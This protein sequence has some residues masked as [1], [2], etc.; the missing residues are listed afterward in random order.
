MINIFVHLV[1]LFHYIY[2][3]IFV[4][5]LSVHFVGMQDSFM[6]L[7]T[8]NVG[9]QGSLMPP[10]TSNVMQ[11]VRFN[12]LFMWVWLCYLLRNLGHIFNKVF[13][14]R[15][16]DLWGVTKSYIMPSNG[17]PHLFFSSCTYN[18][19]L[20]SNPSNILFQNMMS[21]YFFRVFM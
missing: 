17:S 20:T 12:H 3:L 14:Q 21:S 13:A 4:F 15:L 10:Y 16:H 9:M 2:L 1:N 7:N 11:N 5:L 6:P 19:I 18:T 8:T